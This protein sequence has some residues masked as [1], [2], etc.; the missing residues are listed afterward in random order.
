MKKLTEIVFLTETVLLAKDIFGYKAITHK[1]YAE[2][3]K[4]ALHILR[5]KG[6]DV[7]SYLKGE[8]HE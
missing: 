2:I 5:A 7:D 8:T 6:Y 3:E 1:A 4:A